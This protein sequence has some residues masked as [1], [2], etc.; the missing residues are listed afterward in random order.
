MKQ[1]VLFVTVLMLI[2]PFWPLAEYIVN[3]DYIV[4]NLCENRNR[5]ALNCDGKCY[6][7]K[8]LAKEKES[9]DKN[10]FDGK[11]LL[12]DIQFFNSEDLDVEQCGLDFGEHF[13]VHNFKKENVLISR[14]FTSDIAQPPELG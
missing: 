7:S 1:V 8:Q 4:T 13:V 10:P 3:Y 6:L 5:P 11:R 12:T 9:E 14:L 2:K